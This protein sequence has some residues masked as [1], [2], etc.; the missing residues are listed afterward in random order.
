MSGELEKVEKGSLVLKVPGIS[1][2]PKLPVLGLRSLIAM[3]HP[4]AA[5]LPRSELTGRL[6]LDGLRLPGRLVDG[7]AHARRELSGLA[8]LGQ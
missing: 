7:R 8:I 6:E 4:D 5:P 3:R 1:R 2:P